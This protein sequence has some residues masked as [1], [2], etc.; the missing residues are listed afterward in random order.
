M[1]DSSWIK[2]VN[3]P[4]C[5]LKFL[6]RRVPYDPYKTVVYEGQCETIKCTVKDFPN[7]LVAPKDKEG[8]KIALLVE[9][10]KEYENAEDKPAWLKTYWSD[11]EIQKLVGADILWR[12]RNGYNQY[13]QSVYNV[14][15]N[16]KSYLCWLE[17]SVVVQTQKA[18]NKR[19]LKFNVRQINLLAHGEKGGLN[20]SD[21]DGEAS[22]NGGYSQ[23][24]R[25]R[26]SDR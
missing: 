4:A 16:S 24:K 8:R 25:P 13:K 9:R 21:D 6:D 22:D 19:R 26:N 15:V 10:A 12:A 1:G 14:L 23:A 18:N 17:S 11:P 7:A 5:E 2:E 20:D 3:K